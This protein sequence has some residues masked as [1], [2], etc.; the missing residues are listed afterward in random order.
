MSEFNDPNLNMPP[1]PG[2]VPEQRWSPPPRVE[3]VDLKKGDAFVIDTAVDSVA[4]NS[5]FGIPHESSGLSSKLA[6]VGVLEVN[7]KEQ[8]KA[9]KVTVVKETMA[10]NK[11]DL[12]WLVSSRQPT[13]DDPSS[14]SWVPL[15]L[16]V[17]YTVGRS[18]TQGLPD[19]LDGKKLTGKEFVDDVSRSH[20]EV[21]LTRDGVEVRD[22]S[23]NGTTVQG[24]PNRQAMSRKV[25]VQDTSSSSQA[26]GFIDKVPKTDEESRAANAAREAQRVEVHNRSIDEQIQQLT[27][28]RNRLGED[29]GLAQ[30]DYIELDAFSLAKTMKARWQE[31]GNGEMS[32]ASDQNISTALNRMS[33]R[34]RGIADQW[35]RYDKQIDQLKDRLRQS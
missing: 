33:S 10:Q 17:K 21:S 19:F 12:F 31:S 35:H 2:M 34:A 24:V 1:P 14:Q 20:F 9:A 23:T 16:G 8:R 25:E 7:G 13:E 30:G 18:N 5:E 22:L 26:S 4:D 28:A 6:V 3:R 29:A 15:P 11:F 27:A 32:M